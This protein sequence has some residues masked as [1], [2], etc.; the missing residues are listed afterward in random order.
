V[1]SRPTLELDGLE[2]SEIDAA[3]A[4]QLQDAGTL[5]AV[6]EELLR[7]LAP[8]VV[9]TQDLCQVCA[10][11]GNEL[12]RALADLPQRPEVVWLTPRSVGEI[13]ENFRAVGRATGRTQ[14][15]EQLVTETMSRMESVRVRAARHRVRTMVFLEWVSPYYCAGHWVPEMIACA[16]GHDPLARDGADSVRVSW[17]EVVAAGPSL[18]VVSPCGYALDAAVQLARSLPSTGIE[19]WAVDA[20]AYFARPGP[21]LSEGTELLA[22]IL[23]PSGY[24]PPSVDRAA[25]VA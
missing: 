10:P 9:L 20:N 14:E 11:S 1:V 18:I 12:T 8:E 24:G 2:Q 22:S 13:C 3:V 19:T 23:H 6:D 21:R 7:A 4:R 25:R 15:A 17:D 5:Y 16:G